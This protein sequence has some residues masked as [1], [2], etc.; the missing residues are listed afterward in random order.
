MRAALAIAAK[1]VRQ[2]VRDRS[3]YIFAFAAPLGLAAI[4]SFVFNPIGELDFSATYAVVDED[5]GPIARG[6]VDGVL[7]ELAADSDVEL[8]DLASEAEAARLLE[9]DSDV[10]ADAPDIDAAIII[11][12]GFSA[13]VQAGQGSELRVLGSASATT[14]SA[15]AVAVVESY[16]HEL[17]YLQGAVATLA[18]LD[19]ARLAD[20]DA[21]VA[22]AAAMARPITVR[23]VSASTKQLDYITFYAAGVA[24]FFL[25]FTAQFGV[26]GLLE[27]RHAGTLSRLLAAPI[28]KWS[29]VLGKAITAFALGLVSMLVLVVATSLLFGADWGNPGGV[30]LLVVAGTASAI[31]VTSVVGALARTAEQA[32]VFTSIIAVVLGILGGTFFPV[33]QAGGFLASLRFITPHGWFMQGLGDLAGGSVVDVIPATAAMIGFA[34]VSSVI[35]LV[36]L[37]RGLNP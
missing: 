28:P 26:N 11:P 1:D 24:I 20:A 16:A 4:F 15:L 9:G 32:A 33:S 12:R 29:I 36:L 34:A 22:R 31:G 37:R 5:G 19:P 35:A 30:A 23:D 10:A 6:L 13:R 3:L 18:A 21:V 2:R 8:I 7:G 14:A 27:E 25:F 17:E